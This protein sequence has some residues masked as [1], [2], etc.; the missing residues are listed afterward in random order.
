MSGIDT[1][2]LNI[3]LSCIKSINVK[4]RDAVFGFVRT[5]QSLLDTNNP[6]YNIPDL[7]S[8][9]CLI[10]YYISEY[11]T[12]YGSCIQYNEQTNTITN[13]GDD[14]YSFPNTG[15]GKLKYQTVQIILFMFGH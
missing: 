9:I 6:C 11:F 15:Y 4:S 13:I 7:V 2:E 3:S 1:N 14:G 10:Y 12:V 5:S 8:Y